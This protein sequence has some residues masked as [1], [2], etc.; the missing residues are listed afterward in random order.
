[1]LFFLLFPLKR[2]KKKE[3]RVKKM[4]SR[5]PSQIRVNWLGCNDGLR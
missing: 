5:C 2:R 1:M 4:V 3:G